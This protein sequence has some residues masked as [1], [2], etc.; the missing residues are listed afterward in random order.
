[1]GNDYE[2]QKRFKMADQ[3]I[4]NILDV[5]DSVAMI[6]YSYHGAYFFDFNNSETVGFVPHK[7]FCP[8]RCSI[9]KISDHEL[10]IGAE[11]TIVL[12]DYK[13]YQKIKEFDNDASY[14]L[15]KLSD[16]YLLTSYG[17]GFLQ[18]HEMSRDKNG[19]LEL[20]QL[21]RNKIID[22][23]VVGIALL[24]DGRL[25]ILSK[26]DNITVWNPKK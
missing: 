20:K 2:K 24:R 18:T 16:K 10:L 13:K 25:M 12:I 5:S 14:A 26:D 4:L 17:N 11:Y 9:L 8:F 1:M 19:Q 15:Y 22:D 6:T 21:N 3:A 23:I 7:L